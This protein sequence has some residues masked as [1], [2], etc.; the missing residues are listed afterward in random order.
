[1]GFAVQGRHLGAQAVN[2]SYIDAA[3]LLIQVA[4]A[5][6][7]SGVFALKGGTAINLFIRDMPRL[8]VDLDLVSHNRPLHEVLSPVPRDITQDFE[9]T[10]VGM[11]TEPVKLADLLS[12]RDRLMTE[13]PQTLDSNERQFLLSLVSNAPDWPLLNIAHLERLPAVRWKLKNLEQ[14]AKTSPAKF[15]EQADALKRLLE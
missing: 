15:S 8:S 10:F 4:P 7:E 11:T 1:M 13:L 2:Q 5:V 14:L 3:R 9:R 12:V 6:F